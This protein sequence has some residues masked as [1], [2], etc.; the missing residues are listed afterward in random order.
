MRKT[1]MMNLNE[2]ILQLYQTYKNILEKL[3]AGLLNQQSVTLLIETIKKE[4]QQTKAYIFQSKKVEQLEPV[5]MD[6]DQSHTYRKDLNWQ[7]SDD[8]PRVQERQQ[9]KD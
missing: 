6:I 7:H 1:V 3:Q 2:S 9:V 5:Q 8:E 4:A